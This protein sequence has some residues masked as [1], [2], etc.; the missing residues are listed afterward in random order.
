MN[1]K[2]CSGGRAPTRTRCDTRELAELPDAAG[3]PR[4][5]LEATN[6][7]KTR[8][9]GLGSGVDDRSQRERSDRVFKDVH[10]TEYSGHSTATLVKRDGRRH[11]TGDDDLLRRHW[12]VVCADRR[13]AGSR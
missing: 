1:T 3:A 2:P 9:R 4:S 11:A 7:A 10:G 8:S 13:G 5:T 6:N 12:F